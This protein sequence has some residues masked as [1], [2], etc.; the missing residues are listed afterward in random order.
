[1]VSFYAYEDA[2]VFMPRR[3]IFIFPKVFGEDTRPSPTMGYG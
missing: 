1:M 3:G 2:A